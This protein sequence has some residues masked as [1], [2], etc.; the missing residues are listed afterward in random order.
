MKF[1]VE[2]RKSLRYIFLKRYTYL[3]LC[4][5]DEAVDERHQ[6]VRRRPGEDL[7]ADCVKQCQIP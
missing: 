4:F 2:H 1:H 7:L 5:S 3:N 6:F